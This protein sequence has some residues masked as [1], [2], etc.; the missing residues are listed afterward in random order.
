VYKEAYADRTQ[1]TFKSMR[2]DKDA[3]L[4]EGEKF[5]QKINNDPD[6]VELTDIQNLLND[7]FQKDQRHNAADMVK[8]FI[9][10]LHDEHS[11]KE[12]FMFDESQSD[13]EYA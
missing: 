4:K 11:E 8:F 9:Q 3:P 12:D 1:P 7:V 6:P 5:F 2:R 10:L 13:N